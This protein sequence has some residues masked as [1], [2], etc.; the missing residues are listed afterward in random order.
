LARTSGKSRTP[1]LRSILYWV[2]IALVCSLFFG[3]G[4]LWRVYH[5]SSRAFAKARGSLLVAGLRGHELVAATRIYDRNGEVLASAFVEN[6]RPISLD[7]MSPWVT[8]GII[9]TEDKSFYQH[10]G[11]SMRGILR[12][13]WV[14]LTTG[15]VHGG[16]TITQQLAR[17]LFLVPEQTIQRKIQEAFIA[18]EIERQFSKDQI[19]EMYLN[20]ICFGAGAY[21][22][23]SAAR[24]FFGGTN[25]RELTL[26]QA[27]MLVGLPRNPSGFNPESNPRRCLNRRNVVISMME[28]ENIITARQAEEARAAPLRFEMHRPELTQGWDYFTEHVRKYLVSRYGWSAVY[29]QGLEVYTTLDPEMQ[30]MA[31]EALDSVLRAKEPEWD[32]QT[33]EFEENPEKLRNESSYE[34]WQAVEDT[35]DGSPDY[36]QGALVAVEPSTGYVRAMVGGRD[37]R[38]SEFNRAVQARRQPG[39]AFKP[40]VYAEAM[41]QGW[42][43]GSVILDQPVVVEL[44]PG[45]WRPRNYDRRFHGM[46]TLRDALARSYNVSAVKLGAAVGIESVAAR[47]RAM[48]LESYLPIVNSLPLGS[49]MVDPLEMAQ[50][51][52]PFATGGMARD[53]TSILR[54]ED[55]Y[56]NVLES[57]EEPDPGRRVLSRTAAY[58]MNSMLQSVLRGGTGV[59]ARWYGGIGVPYAGREAGGKT[60]TT[61]DYADA[62]FVGFTP[63]LV[64]SVWVGYDNHIV[65]LRLQREWNS[66]QSGSSIALPIWNSFMRKVFAD[67]DPD[68]APSFPGPEAGELERATICRIT[69]QLAVA[70][71]GGYAM[72]E[73]FWEGSA[74]EEYCMLHAGESPLDADT[75]I[76]DFTEFD[77]NH[78]YRNR[79]G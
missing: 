16:S 14:D 62:W 55:R 77:R 54:V 29:E 7:E 11:I 1:A 27:A 19:L 70:A 3:A 49:C 67:A 31:E 78:I 15:A 60:G 58:L 36:V 40:F 72:E 41:E 66:G 33:G 61:S 42:S 4:F 26:T 23:E 28:E 69:G 43:P 21:G 65:R 53:V 74:P 22:I 68:E 9:A 17:R 51:Y 37:F 25:A 5:D 47:A 13:A 50:A 12:A 10:S 18:M 71:C 45:E 63:D 24:T 73:L 79:G 35:T 6:R 64:T 75:T 48:G 34:H 20:Q 52:I 32:P 44:D 2:G 30:R 38:D 59:G 76:P 56:G 8:R 39:S 46:C 57:N